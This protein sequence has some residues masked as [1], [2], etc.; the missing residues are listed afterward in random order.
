MGIFLQIYLYVLLV[1][2]IAN[3]AIHTIVILPEL[4][5]NDPDTKTF[6]LP[7]RSLWAFRYY[8]DLSKYKAICLR[9]NKPLIWHTVSVQLQNIL[10]LGLI[11]WLL[12]VTEADSV[13]TVP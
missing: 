11:V 13:R 8:S 2:I 4:R 7:S 5:I 12:L 10:W 3:L 6:L 1:L 9:D